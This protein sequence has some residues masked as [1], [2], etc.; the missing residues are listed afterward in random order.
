MRVVRSKVTGPAL[1]EALF[2][3]V[4][5]TSS[6]LFGRANGVHLRRK[7]GFVSPRA[8]T[9]SRPHGHL[10]RRRTMPHPSSSCG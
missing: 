10:M 5:T 8:N 2:D 4:K 6:Q 1:I 7:M 3:K 9:K